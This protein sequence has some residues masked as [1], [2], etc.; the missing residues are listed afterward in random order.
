MTDLPAPG[1]T[2]P[3]AGHAN[4]ALAAVEAAARR[5]LAQLVAALPPATAPTDPLLAHLAWDL[6]LAGDEVMGSSR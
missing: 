1:S 6:G 4:A 2:P 5:E 3:A